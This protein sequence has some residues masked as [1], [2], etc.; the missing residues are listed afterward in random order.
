[1]FTWLVQLMVGQ[2]PRCPNVIAL[3]QVL[4]I[5]MKMELN[6]TN[7]L[8]SYVFHMPSRQ[9]LTLFG[10]GIIVLA[11]NLARLIHQP[12]KMQYRSICQA[13]LKRNF[14]NVA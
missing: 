1:M 13:Y 10:S 11:T 8:F 3:D 6:V 5:Y 9:V 2:L 7:V 14:Q 4:L 12:S